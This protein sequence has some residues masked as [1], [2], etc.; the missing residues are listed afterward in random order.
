MGFANSTLAEFLAAALTDFMI[1]SKFVVSLYTNMN[2]ENSSSC[3][4]RPQWPVKVLGAVISWSA[5][6]FVLLLLIIVVSY[7][8]LICFTFFS[9]QTYTKYIYIVVKY[10]SRSLYIITHH[11]K[12][13]DVH[14]NYHSYFFAFLHRVVIVKSDS[15]ITQLCQFHFSDDMIQSI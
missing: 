7:F 9:L 14:F 5:I 6:A 3:S 11:M 15:I 10:C 2:V 1:L 12:G 13:L 8:G 4:G